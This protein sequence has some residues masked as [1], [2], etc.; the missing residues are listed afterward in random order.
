M[1]V[2]GRISNVITESRS[3]PKA[4]RGML[5]LRLSRDLHMAAVF[6]VE[7]K[8]KKKKKQ[9][10]IILFHLSRGSPAVEMTMNDPTATSCFG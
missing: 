8:V 3:E 9:N 5:L 6:K 1:W 7:L 4:H 10:Q 2:F